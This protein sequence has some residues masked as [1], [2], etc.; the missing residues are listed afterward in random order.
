MFSSWI[1]TRVFRILSS[2]SSDGTS[3]PIDSTWAERFAWLSITSAVSG[4]STST[5]LSVFGA[6]LTG[7]I[8]SGL[9]SGCTT[10]AVA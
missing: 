4:S 5:F 8:S 9:V 10:W 2:K 1:S 3:V 7:W 6:G